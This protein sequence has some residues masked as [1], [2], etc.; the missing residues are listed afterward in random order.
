MTDP[1][2]HAAKAA[3]ENLSKDPEVRRLARARKL[4]EWRY[5]RS[6][7]LTRAQG[8]AKGRAEGE[9]KGRAEGEAHALRE[10]VANLCRLH[11]VVLTAEQQ[12]ELQ[13]ASSPK[14]RRCFEYVAR[15][16]AWPGQRDAA[17]TRK[18]RSRRAR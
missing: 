5:E 11:G 9:A 4:A 13:G 10:S 15:H 18:A 7:A 17:G 8:E 12:L 3:L 1:Q 14:L 2:I 16:R 6:L